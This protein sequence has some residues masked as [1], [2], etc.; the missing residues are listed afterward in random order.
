M[1]TLR[2][3][4]GKDSDEANGGPGGMASSSRWNLAC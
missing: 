1:Q 2:I 4:K 3:G